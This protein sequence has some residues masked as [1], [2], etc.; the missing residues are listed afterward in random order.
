VDAV[1][2]AGPLTSLPQ[3]SLLPLHCRGWGSVYRALAEGQ[4][5]VEPLRAALAAHPPAGVQPVYAIDLSVWPRR[6]AEASPKRGY[7]YHP[8][9][10]SAGPLIVAGWAYQWLAQVSLARE[11]WAVPLDV[12]R[13]HPVENPNAVAAEQIAALVG[14]F[15]ASDPAPLFVFDAG[16]DPVRLTQGLGGVPAAILVRLRSDRRF[17]ADPPPA[18][19]SSKDG[20][21]RTHGDKF[22][23]KA[24]TTWPRPSAEHAA[25]DEQYGMVRVQ[26]WAGLHPKQQEH[27]TRGTGRP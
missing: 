19:P 6:D 7:Y 18:A 8:S 10:H 12:R 1:L 20:R 13:V 3:L 26:A 4:L 25:E 27:A 16:Y 17:Y 23:C 21:P 24:P 15:P 9:R 5:E 22:A 2:A 14:R 11:S